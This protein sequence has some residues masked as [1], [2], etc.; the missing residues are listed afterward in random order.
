MEHD[1]GCSM[2][3]LYELYESR[4]C[5]WIGVEISRERKEGRKKNM[6]DV[7]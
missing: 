6:Y 5:E 3:T 4:L 1:L 2:G 7:D